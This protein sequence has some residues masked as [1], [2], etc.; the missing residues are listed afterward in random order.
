MGLASF[1]RMR[2]L[3]AEAMNATAD[4]KPAGEA[5]PPKGSKTGTLVTG[6]LSA[7]EVLALATGNF[8]AFKSA[9]KKL[10]GDTLPGTKDEIIA[11]LNAYDGGAD[12]PQTPIPEAWEAMTDD[13]LIAL[14]GELA[15]EPIIATGEATPA[16]KARSVI[17]ATVEDRARNG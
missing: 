6:T 13:E 8:M 2:R 4:V 11:A 16:D 14:A 3:Q 5:K 9:A 10:L 12:D 17:Q 7:A 15:G 1:N